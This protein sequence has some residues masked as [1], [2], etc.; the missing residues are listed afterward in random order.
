MPVAYS[1]RAHV[2][3]AAVK[4]RGGMSVGMA[5]SVVLT[6]VLWALPDGARAWFLEKNLAFWSKAAEKYA[7]LWD[8]GKDTTQTF[9]EKQLKSTREPGPAVIQVMQRAG[10]HYS[11]MVDGRPQWP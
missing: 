11:G 3:S 5:T 1:R 9:V 2:E 7:G 8:K 10:Y 6:V 4:L